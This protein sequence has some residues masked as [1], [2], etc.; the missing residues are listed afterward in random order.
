MNIMN[1]FKANKNQ[2]NDS[3]AQ[4][5]YT[6]LNTEMYKSGSWRTEDN[7]EDMAIVSQVPHVY[8]NTCV[9]VYMWT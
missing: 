4:D 8:V 3:A 1:F 5:L 9:N 2:G 7:G 6:K